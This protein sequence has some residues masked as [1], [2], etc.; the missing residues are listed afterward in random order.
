MIILSSA[1]SGVYL[2]RIARER[3]CICEELLVF[4]DMLK[5]DI[6]TRRTELDT[7]INSIADNPCLSHISFINS[8]FIC[9]KKEV[10]SVL[11]RRDNKRITEFLSSLGS[12][13]LS[14]QL[15]EIEFFS[16]F[17]CS[18][19]AEYEYTL[20]T[21]S[22]LYFTLCFSFGCIVSLVII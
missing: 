9:G 17:I 19:K 4:C 12:F 13:D 18:R 11:M 16:S 10:T 15:N 22:R 21:K 8:D 6:S 1:M 2:I 3:I 7:L 5:N 14:A 20:K